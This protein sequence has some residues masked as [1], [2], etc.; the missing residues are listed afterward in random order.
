MREQIKMVCQMKDLRSRSSRIRR[1]TAVVSRSFVLP[2]SR[3][4]AVSPTTYCCILA[5]CHCVSHCSS[6][7]YSFVERRRFSLGM[8]STTTTAIPPAAAK[9]HPANIAVIGAG[10]AGLVAARVLQRDVP[11]CIVTVLEQDTALGGVWKYS[12][13]DNKHHPMYRGLRTNLPKEVMGYREFPWNM[14][15]IDGK[16][17]SSTPSSYVAHTQVLQ[18]L[19][20]YARTFSLD[21]V[22]QFGAKV[23]QLTVLSGTWSRFQPSNETDEVWPLIRLDWTTMASTTDTNQN[24]QQ[25]EHSQV[26]DA[27]CVCNGHYNLPQIPLVPGLTEFFK[28]QTMHSIAYDD[29]QAFTGKTVLCVGGRASGSD[30]ARELSG[31]ATHVYL[32]ES[33]LVAAPPETPNSR[34]TCVPRTL[35]VLPDG[36]IQFDHSICSPTAVDCIIFCTG[37]DY[38]FPFFNELSNCPLEASQRRVQP[39]LEQLWH[40]QYPNIALVGLPHSVVPFPLFELQ[41]EAFTSQLQNWTLM[42][43]TSSTT[44]DGVATLQANDKH[45][46][47]GVVTEKPGHLPEDTHYLGDL[48]WEYCRRMAL[49]AQ[50]L[51]DTL[52]RYLE[53]NKVIGHSVSVP[54]VK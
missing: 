51:D 4:P 12:K 20:D 40:A 50:Q 23:E 6:W 26:F 31:F 28:G 24:T 34:V 38:F 7:A 48:Q 14:D 33:A 44:T 36:R 25:Q 29:P 19:K 5:F 46:L 42:S 39:L 8:T 10:P 21:S 54:C 22:L 11:D 2:F 15:V 27:V 30:I 9:D 37:Y 35:G 49:A 18:Y 43:T 3:K 52:Q 32:S 16:V 45:H 41:M 17:P 53:T 13:P 1:R 47:C